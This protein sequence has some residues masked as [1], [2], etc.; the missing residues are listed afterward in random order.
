MSD[1]PTWEQWQR[2]IG[3][4][5][6]NTRVVVFGTLCLGLAS[7][8]VGCFTVL[9]RRALV[10]DALAHATL[11]GMAVA[12][13]LVQAWGGD[14]K[15]LVGLLTGATVSGLLGVVCI[16]FLRRVMR[17]REDA[18][19]GMVLSVFFGLGVA[20]LGIVQQLPGGH[21]AGL[22]AF[23]YGKTASMVVGDAWLIGGAAIACL[24]L[25][26]FFFKEL[27]LLCFDE[28][29]AGARGYSTLWLD[30][31]MM[32]MV[33][34]VT[35]VGLQAVGL[36]LMVALLVI[37]PVTARFWASQLRGMTIVASLVGALSCVLGA[38]LSGVLPRLPSGPMIVLISAGFF[39]LSLTFG[40]QGGWLVRWRRRRQ[41]YQRMDRDHLLRSMY[42]SWELDPAAIDRGW[43]LE[44]WK[45]ERSWSA[46]RLAATVRRC[47]RA[48]WVREM[49]GAR[50]TLTQSGVLEGRRLVREHR[51]WEVYLITHADV[52]PSRVDHEAD[53][54]EHV[55]EPELIAELEASWLAATAEREWVPRNPHQRS[56]VGEAGAL[57]DSVG[58]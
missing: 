30:A 21:A 5:D 10:G 8:F 32:G 20:G 34:L 50:W 39:V 14:G 15:S 19:L 25:G 37:P 57:P 51:L 12:F 49:D 11:P 40:T 7:G 23:I 35:M 42:E 44:P 47:R 36:V 27:Q 43:T 18:A 2:V 28:G 17:I 29:Y 46:R 56:A 48:G 33:V 1:W 24:L 22:E 45:A 53:R 41:L 52:A 54:I 9:R 16:T 4:H 31:V 55:L 6:Y 3:L 38:M 13:A 26:C 58:G